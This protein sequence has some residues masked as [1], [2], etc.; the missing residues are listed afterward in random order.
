MPFNFLL[1][2]QFFF[3]NFVLFIYNQYNSR[4]FPLYCYCNY[5]CVLPSVG[6]IKAVS[7]RPILNRK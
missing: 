5:G 2:L 1:S 7:S 6:I 3:I 4:S